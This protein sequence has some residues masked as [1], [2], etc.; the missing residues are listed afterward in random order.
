[1]SLDQRIRRALRDAGVDA[2]VLR[3]AEQTAS[4][5]AR[6]DAE[7]V[8]RFFDDGTAFYSDM[9]RTHDTEQF[10]E[11]RIEYVD[12]FTHAQDVRGYVRFDSWGAYV[13]GARPISEDVVELSLGPTVH[14]RVRF[15]QERAAL[16]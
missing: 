1:M 15:A 10:P 4:E 2:A 9:D 13:A 11:H 5:T 6:E 14:G 8:E 16:R 7:R 12:L 3:E